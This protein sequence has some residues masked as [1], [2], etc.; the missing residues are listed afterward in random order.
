MNMPDPYK[1]LEQLG[2]TLPSPPAPGGNYMPAR[3]LGSIV[4]LSGVISQTSE[5]LVTG[6]VGLDRS[7]EEGYAAARSCAM[8]QLAVLER[9][10]GSLTKIRSILSVNGYV[11]S[12]FGFANSPEVINGASDVFLSVFGEAGR[13]VRAALGVSGLPRNAIVELQMTVEI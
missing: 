7:I 8:L 10:L 2:L 6:C 4:Y 1:A 12:V 13:H 5:G 11:N 3:T 9:H